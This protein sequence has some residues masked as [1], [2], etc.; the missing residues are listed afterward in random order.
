MRYALIIISF[1]LIALTSCKSNQNPVLKIEGGLI[2]GVETETPG[3]YVYKGIPYAAPPVGDLRWKAPQPVIPWEGVKVADTY[4]PAAMQA[5]R[6]PGSFYYIEFFTDDGH[7]V[8]EDC[9]Y[10]NVY[11]SSPGKTNARLPV[12]VYIHG[13][14]YASGYCYEKQFLGG[15]EWMK[16]G[17]ILVTINYRLNLFGFLAHPELSAEDAHGVS[18]N[19]GILDQIA[20]LKWVKNNIHQFGGNPDNVTVFGQSAGAMSIQQLITSPLSKDLIH[21]AIMQSGG[22]ISDRPSLG[23]SQLEAAEQAG[24][25]MMELGGYK[26]LEA[27]RSAPVDSIMA[28]MNRARRERRGGMMGPVADGYV[29]TT[30][31]SEATRT[32]KI[33]DI[34][35]IIGYNTDDMGMMKNGL[36][37]FCLSRETNGG[38]AYAYEFSRALPGDSAGAFHSAELWYV[39]KTL[40]KSWRPFTDGDYV[41]SDY[42]VDFWTNFAKY[43]NP[44]GKEKEVWLPY[45][46]ANQEFMV[47]KLNDEGIAEASMMLPSNPQ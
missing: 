40:D 32:D 19:Y 18:G 46:E 37:Q 15:E 33:A 39:F 41:L 45:T 42:M 43:G 7:Q 31:F 35:Y 13:G 34:P 23:G 5:P 25:A 38:K 36:G 47:F 20:A 4:G 6:Q 22:G 11:T 8:S 28:L 27:M 24:K 21:K 16:H 9:L 44:N 14:A 10:L 2:Q 3:I 26:N 17:V 12:A 29:L 30:S 1:L